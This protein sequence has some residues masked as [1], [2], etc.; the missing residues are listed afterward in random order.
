MVETEAWAELDPGTGKAEDRGQVT[1]T[2]QSLHKH[3]R[4]CSIQYLPVFALFARFWP[5][6]IGVLLFNRSHFE[7]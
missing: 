4:V 1:H 7:Y 5:A 3:R 2:I 6:F